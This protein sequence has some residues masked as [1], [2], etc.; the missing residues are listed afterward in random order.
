MVLN[1]IVWSANLLRLDPTPQLLCRISCRIIKYLIHN[2]L[3]VSKINS[4]KRHCESSEAILLFGA[5]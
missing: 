2:I 4:I 1:S 5:L 3:M